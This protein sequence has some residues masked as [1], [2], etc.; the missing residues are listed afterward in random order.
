M[1]REA[2]ARYD[3]YA[4]T[5]TDGALLGP[6]PPAGRRRPFPAEALAAVLAAAASSSISATD[7]RAERYGTA[8]PARNLHLVASATVRGR[9]PLSLARTATLLGLERAGGK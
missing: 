3:A 2:A 6:S 9:D 8:F 1:H 4:D 7:E 5:R